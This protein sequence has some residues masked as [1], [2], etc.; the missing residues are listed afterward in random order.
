[1]LPAPRSLME[2][3]KFKNLLWELIRSRYQ[4]LQ[5]EQKKLEQLFREPVDQH[6]PKTAE[7]C[8][9]TIVSCCTFIVN[10]KRDLEITFCKYKI[11]TPSKLE[12]ALYQEYVLFGTRIMDSCRASFIK[13]GLIRVNPQNMGFFFPLNYQSTQ[14]I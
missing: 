12:M 2:C 8:F 10:A 14:L 4:L 11:T 3:I 1:M 9:K 7:Q 13:T 5:S 6:T